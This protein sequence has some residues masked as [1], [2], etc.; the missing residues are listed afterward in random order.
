M[1][2]SR[3]ETKY[4]HIHLAETD[5]TNSYARREAPRL[6]EKNPEHKIIIITAEKQ[7]S[8]RGQRG[9]V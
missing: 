7:T 8:G 2:Y 5:S 1:E 6:S 4:A 3:K 9:T